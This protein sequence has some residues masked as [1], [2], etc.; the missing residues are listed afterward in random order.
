M[1][2]DL[3]RLEA[4]LATLESCVVTLSGGVDSA[5]V[6]LAAARALGDRAIALTAASAALPVEELEV[7]RDVAARVGIGHRVV[8]GAELER[9][10]YRANAG[11]R[12]YFCKT[13]LFDLAEAERLARGFL[14]VC[15]GTLPSDARDHR[16][17]RVAAAEHRVR[18][19]LVEAGL[20]K[21][22]V[23][24]IA[25]EHGLP[26]WDK[27]AF[28]CLGSR[29]PAGTP[30]DLEKLRRV[31]RAESALRGLGLGRV[32]VRWHEIGD[33]V[34]ARIEVDPAQLQA[35]T[36]P[37]VR[38]R[39]VAACLEAGFSWATLDLAG[40]APPTGHG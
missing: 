28:A 7:A 25:R 20:D 32:R 34:L 12:C 24:A 5:V 36:A 35:L 22:E 16:P 37:G 13:E 3:E 26:V 17:G 15:D 40:Y 11:N 33:R 10:G 27:P 6:A 30:V 14:W 38:E 4:V 1:S 9:E 21:P 23:R 29:F 18:H 31:G 2:A 19:P 8:E 39:A